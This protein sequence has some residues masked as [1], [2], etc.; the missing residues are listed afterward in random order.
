MIE[1]FLTKGVQVTDSYNLTPLLLLAE[2]LRFYDEIDLKA[3]SKIV[4][5]MAY[6]GVD[7]DACNENGETAEDVIKNELKTWSKYEWIDTA[8]YLVFLTALDTA[9]FEQEKTIKS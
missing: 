9:R 2:K 3:L 1:W 4:R 8:C 5:L 7:I 6:A